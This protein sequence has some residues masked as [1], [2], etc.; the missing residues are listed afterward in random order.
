MSKKNCRKSLY[1]NPCHG[2]EAIRSPQPLPQSTQMAFDFP[3]TMPSSGIKSTRS[4]NATPQIS[5][6][7]Q[8]HRRSLRHNGVLLCGDKHIYIIIFK[9]MKK[10]ELSMCE[11]E[12]WDPCNTPAVSGLEG[13]KICMWQLHTDSYNRPNSLL[14]LCLLKNLRNKLWLTCGRN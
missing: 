10:N 9:E 13:N 3:N 2:C 12:S 4:L 6:P 5:A 14:S 1:E 7:W 8:R 11:L